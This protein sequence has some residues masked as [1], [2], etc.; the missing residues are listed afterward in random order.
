[1][2]ADAQADAR[3]IEPNLVSVSSIL[4]MNPTSEK[5]KLM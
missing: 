3:P 1:M 4:T 2:D 5:Y